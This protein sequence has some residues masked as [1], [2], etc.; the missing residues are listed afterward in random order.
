MRTIG[1]SAAGYPV[2]EFV[3]SAK[4]TLAKVEEMRRLRMAEGLTYTEIGERFGVSRTTAAKAVKGKTWAVSVA[5]LV[6]Q[7]EPEDV[8]RLSAG[9]GRGL[10]A[11]KAGATKGSA[12]RAMKKAGIA[13]DGVRRKEKHTHCQRGHALEGANLVA[14]KDG[15]QACKECMRSAQ[16]EWVRKRRAALKE[17][18]N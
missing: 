8:A 1:V 15:R 16:R 10:L 18:A 12:Y 9:E 13:W 17:V 4:L 5:K 2:G 11:K 3:P 7:L 6:Q 14:R